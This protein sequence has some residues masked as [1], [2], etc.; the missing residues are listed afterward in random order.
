MN[1]NNWQR[2]LNSAKIWLLSGLY[3]F[4]FKPLNNPYEVQ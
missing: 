3:P 1:I 2:V 4:S